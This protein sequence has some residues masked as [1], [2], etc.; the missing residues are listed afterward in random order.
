MPRKQHHHQHPRSRRQGDILLLRIPAI[1][2]DARKE[3]RRPDASILLGEGE[4][5]GHRHEIL[6]PSVDAYR[7]AEGLYLEATEE[8]AALVHPD[9][10]RLP[11]FPGSQEVIHQYEFIRREFRQVQ[12]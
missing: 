11:L 5:A 1:P 6:H 2:P 12:D 7:R 8:D 3:S 4:T 9:H 10:A